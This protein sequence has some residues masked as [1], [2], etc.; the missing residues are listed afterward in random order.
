MSIT[1]K[2]ATLIAVIEQ[3]QSLRMLAL[4]NGLES[5]AGFCEDTIHEA[6]AQ[7]AALGLHPLLN[8][9]SP[10]IQKS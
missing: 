1:D 4:R 10:M 8:R 2:A 3:N 5:V 9:P 7:L 6:R